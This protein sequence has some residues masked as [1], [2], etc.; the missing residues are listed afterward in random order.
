MVGST[1]WPNLRG[2]YEAPP[3]H[4]DGNA[5]ASGEP[6]HRI[7]V[8]H[9]DYNPDIDWL[10]LL[11]ASDHPDGGT[12]HKTLRLWCAAIANDP[13]RWLSERHQKRSGAR[14]TAQ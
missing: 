13:D 12:H 10:I 11:H 7:L 2:A 3:N 1:Q 4:P 9:P 5:Q 6:D 14:H 8:R